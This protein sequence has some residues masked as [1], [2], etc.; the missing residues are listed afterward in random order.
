M[1]IEQTARRSAAET[2]REPWE[3]CSVWEEFGMTVFYLAERLCYRA[4]FLM[5]GVCN[6]CLLAAADY[7][8]ARRKC[9]AH[10][11][12][13]FREEGNDCLPGK[14]PVAITVARSPGR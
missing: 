1:K 8:R 5:S 10:V 2:D 13:G 6:R 14:K 4:A 7:W 12:P 9:L 3:P 11:R